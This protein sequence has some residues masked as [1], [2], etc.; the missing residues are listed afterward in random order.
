[1]QN[2]ILTLQYYV[3]EFEDFA[4]FFI[5]HIIHIAS[6][7]NCYELIS[8]SCTAVKHMNNLMI[9]IK[10]LKQNITQLIN[11]FLIIVCF[12]RLA[13]HLNAEDT[14]NDMKMKLLD[15]CFNE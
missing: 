15:N 6:V 4:I 14:I 7:L 12:K 9:M 5:T 8:S 1:M 3:R 2:I 11:Y 10:I 13:K